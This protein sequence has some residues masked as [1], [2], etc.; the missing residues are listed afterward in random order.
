MTASKTLGAVTAALLLAL[1]L[2]GCGQ[3]GKP[4]VDGA[5]IAAAD[6]NS[7]WLSYGKGYSE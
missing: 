3:G 1:A 2:A 7:E 4:G 5:R 6:A